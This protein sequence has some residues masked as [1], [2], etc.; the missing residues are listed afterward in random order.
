MAQ[1]QPQAEP[2]KL[3]LTGRT[4]YDPNSLNKVRP[5]FDT[6]VSKVYAEPGQLVHKGDP[7][8][9]LNSV[10]LAAAKNDLQT[11]YVQWQRDLRVLK[12][13]EKLATEG[14]VSQQT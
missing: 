9:E 5:R 2:I 7:L 8:V 14:A 1:V 12:L 6:L 13:H 3:E 4:A 10:D 11:K